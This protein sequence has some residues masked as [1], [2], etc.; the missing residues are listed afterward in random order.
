[1]VS[2][3]GRTGYPNGDTNS[4]EERFDSVARS[5]YMSI[6]VSLPPVVTRDGEDY[7]PYAAF[8]IKDDNRLRLHIA[9]MIGHKKVDI[10]FHLSEADTNKLVYLFK[11]YAAEK[12]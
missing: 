4:R 8:H 12:R 7:Y 6:E 1:M 3:L 2:T 5:I 10:H 11:D 9:A